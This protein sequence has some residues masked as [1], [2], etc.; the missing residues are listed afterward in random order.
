LTAAQEIE[1]KRQALEQ[2]RFVL[3]AQIKVLRSEFAMEERE[4]DR[5]VKNQQSREA[6]EEQEREAMIRRRMKGTDGKVESVMTNAAGG[7]K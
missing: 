7:V 2:K 4:M 5:F 3:D 6:Q 1:R